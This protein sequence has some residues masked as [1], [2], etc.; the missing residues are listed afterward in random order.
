[1]AKLSNKQE[2]ISYVVIWQVRFR[3]SHNSLSGSQLPGKIRKPP[4]SWLQIT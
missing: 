2:E 3:I 1:M 4:L